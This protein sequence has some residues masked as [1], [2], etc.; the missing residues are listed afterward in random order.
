MNRIA[1]IGATG[2]LGRPVARQLIDAGF[3]VTIVARNPEKVDGFPGARVAR[4]DVFDLPSLES[5][6]AEQDAVYVSLSTD[7]A[8]TATSRHTETDGL[9]NILAAAKENGVRRIGLISSMVKDYQGSNG[10][11]WWAFDVKREAVRL[12]RESGIP[13]TIFYPSSFMENFTA[14]QQKGGKIMLGGK[15]KQ[16]MWFIAGD[17]YGRQ[18][19]R[20]FAMPGDNDREYSVQG[21]EPFTYDEAAVVFVRNVTAKRLRVSRTPLGLIRF[22]GIFSTPMKNLSKI[23][24]ALNDYPETFQSERTWAQLGKPEITLAE[25][26]RREGGG[27]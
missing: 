6:L 22:L 8:G 21:L 2:T 5:A 26:A 7:P 3:A 16:P 4:G 9:R 24:E 11:H 27:G 10:F 15:S 25:F 14:D 19:A 18:V 12:V 23:L 1:V 13:Y 20:S 17:D